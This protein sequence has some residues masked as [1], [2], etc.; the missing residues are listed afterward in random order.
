MQIAD[1]FSGNTESRFL[2]EQQLVPVFQNKVYNSREEAEKALKGKVEL[3][4]SPV[5]G[6]VYNRLFQPDLMVYDINYQNE[7]SNSQVFKD[8][9]QSVLD[10]LISRGI[11]EKKVVEIGCGKGVLFE[12]MLQ[13]GIDCWGFD[14][15]YEGTNPRVI[16]EYFGDEYNDI[17]AGLVIM[18]HTLEHIPNPF[19]FI[20]TIAKA[21]KYKGY[22]FV[23]VPTFDW[24]IKKEA[25]WDI[26]YEHC[27]YFNEQ[28]LGCMFEDAV[29][30]SFF[31][32]QYIYLWADLSKIRKTIPAQD[33]TFYNA[34]AFRKKMKE[35]E[36]LLREKGPVIIWGAGGKGST[37]LNLMDSKRNYISYVVDINPLKQGKFIAGTGH[38]IYSPERLKT[39]PPRT[40]IIMNENYRKEIM[41]M[42]NI[43]GINFISI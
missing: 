5:S 21:N 16:K 11:K 14:P 32:D 17:D 33:F 7:Q 43:P 2:Y 38:P 8:H 10:L 42:V 4:Q 31:G 30:G 37:F 27:N 39:E 25:Y 15:T 18:R 28:S 40:I 23:E 22:I 12:M 29:T 35:H 6:F 20:H 1:N 36:A 19:S 41:E 9:L 34:D 26:F 3:V 13:N 24:I